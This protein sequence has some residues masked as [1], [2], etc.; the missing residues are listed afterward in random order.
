MS[1]HLI[2]EFCCHRLC[3]KL[4]GFIFFHNSHRLYGDRI[5]HVHTHHHAKA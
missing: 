2:E 5:Y 1:E 3:Q 4:T